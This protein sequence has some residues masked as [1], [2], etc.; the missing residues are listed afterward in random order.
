MNCPKCGF[1]NLDGARYCQKCGQDLSGALEENKIQE[2]KNKKKALFWFFF[3]LISLFF[4]FLL[5]ALLHFIFSA[6]GI[7]SFITSIADVV[8]GLLG[9]SCII[10][11]LPLGIIFGVHFINKN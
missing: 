9:I 7:S 8:L 10:I 5:Y 3:P 4:V 1:Q 6:V 2:R 11:G